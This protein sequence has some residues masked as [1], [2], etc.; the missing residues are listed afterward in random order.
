MLKPKYWDNLPLKERQKREKEC[1]E[2]L[3]PRYPE[4]DENTPPPKESVESAF[5]EVNQDLS[6]IERLKNRAN[7][8][9]RSCWR[10]HYTTYI[11]PFKKSV[12]IK[13]PSP[14]ISKGYTLNKEE[15]RIIESLIIQGEPLVETL[16]RV[17]VMHDKFSDIAR[18]WYSDYSN[19]L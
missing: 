7:R 19:P 17:K 8:C 14:H 18:E 6:D 12:H 5:L 4:C 3:H 11:L 2:L 16:R 15:T 13:D 10:R 9:I 1:V